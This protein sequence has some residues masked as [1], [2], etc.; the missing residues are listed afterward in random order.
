MFLHQRKTGGMSLRYQFYR[1]AKAINATT[2][3]ACHG[4]PCLTFAPDPFAT[5]S[6]FAAHFYWPSLDMA[7]RQGQQ[8]GPHLGTNAQFRCF[9]AFREPVQRVTSC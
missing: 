1:A 7:L 9:T 4:K 6:V 3:I 2:F 8:R 5:Q